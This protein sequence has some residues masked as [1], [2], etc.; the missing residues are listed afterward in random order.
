MS[1]V[2]DRGGRG[3]RVVLMRKVLLFLLNIVAFGSL[4]LS[5]EVSIFVMV[6]FFLAC[7]GA[8]FW[9]EPRIDFKRW[10]TPWTVVTLLAFAGTIFDIIS[11]GFF[12]TSAMYFVVFLAAAKL[13][14]LAESK[15]FTQSMALSLLLL[16]SGSVLNEGVSFGAMFALYVI[17]ATLALTT[18]H[19]SV[20]LHEQMADRARQAR[21]ERAVFWSTL[22]LAVLVFLGS[23]GFFFLF[24]RVGIGF[25]MQQNRDGVASSGFGDTVELGQHGTIREDSTVV[26]RVKFPNGLPDHPNGIYF[27]GLSLDHYTGRQWIDQDDRTVGVV[28]DRDGRGYLIGAPQSA[29]WASVT[30]GTTAAD[31]YLE[32]IQ[33]DVI[34]APGQFV[35]FG[36]PDD[37]TDL[38]DAWFDRAVRA[39]ASGEVRL[40][41]RS[42]TG[43]VYR[44]YAN[45]ALAS[46]EAMEMP[47]PSGA[48]MVRD[49]A[50]AVYESLIAERGEEHRAPPFTPDFYRTLRNAAELGG[51]YHALIENYLQLPSD[52]ITPRMEELITSINEGTANTR[53]QA[54]ALE[55]FLRRMEYTTD[56]PQPSSPTA[57][58]IDEFLF[59]WQRGHCEYFATTM[60]VLLRAQGVPARIVNGFLGADYNSVGDFY[61]VRQA[62]AHS[63]VEVYFPGPGW[64]R[65]DPTPASGPDFATEGLMWRIQMWVDSMRLTWF[66]WVIE[67]DL[68]KQV[69]VL[70]DVVQ[71]DA[72]EGGE[73]LAFIQRLSDMLQDSALWFWYHMKP[74]GL[75]MVV[76]VSIGIPLRRRA[77]ARVPW[78]ALDTGLVVLWWALTIAIVAL[79]WREGPASSSAVLLVYLPLIL[80]S[81]Y[82]YQARLGLFDVGGDTSR[83]SGSTFGSIL[84][85]RFLRITERELGELPRSLTS[86]ELVDELDLSDPEAVR[87]LAEFLS[88]YETS[89]FAGVELDADAQREWRTRFKA[90]RKLVVRD[91]RRQEL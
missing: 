3:W 46:V 22:G 74:L 70:R 53:Q 42:S 39:D 11:G 43:V 14:Q 73:Q 58:V 26:M 19:L 36:L 21:M 4:A 86:R 76:W 50:L 5:G 57:N 41:Q 35:A 40:S 69:S 2:V 52:L 29:T 6:P 44:A 89:R 83:S 64:T 38:P 34:F 59:D 54:R 56:L 63:W 48:T 27:R 37:I 33:T 24:P 32:P 78:S 31:I 71:P 61:A 51:E 28:R 18:H 7:I 49:D 62:N 77:R 79:T 65:F 68:E 15:D 90:M 17:V 84:Y 80:A 55:A 72:S 91:L 88:F 85:A 13:F 60:V 67:Y 23:M 87:A 30:D 20:E 12:L 9:E 81:Y 1:A 75:L 45:E 82:A 66:R 16:A 10:Q 8:W 47:Y 25:F